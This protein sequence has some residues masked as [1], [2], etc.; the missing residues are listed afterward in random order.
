MRY[1]FYLLLP[2]F[3]SQTFYSQIVDYRPYQSPVKNQEGR[4]TCTAFSI[5]ALL[6]T[7]PAFPSDISEQHIYGSA[8]LYN[9]NKMPTY[10][11]GALLSFYINELSRRGFWPESFYPY[12]PNSE[13]WNKNFDDMSKLRA[14]L[15]GMKIFDLL[16]FK[17]SPFFVNTSGFRHFNKQE[18]RNIEFIKKTLDS[19]TKA[20][21][22]CYM[23][24]STHL[25]NHEGKRSNKLKPED[26]FVIRKDSKFYTF[27]EIKNSF[28][29]L[30][31]LFHNP[32]FSIIPKK[33]NL[34][35]N[36]GHAV[37]IVGYDE[38][39]FIIKNSWGENWGDKGYGWISFD[40]HTL[41]VKEM[42]FLNNFILNYKKGPFTTA[43]F[44]PSKLHLKSLPYFDK[45]KNGISL[46]WIYESE[47]ILPDLT[48]IKIV[49]YNA[50]DVKIGEWTR[51]FCFKTNIESNGCDLKIAIN[52]LPAGIV[53][54]KIV[55]TFYG[56]GG[57]EF[58]NT[59]SNIS[60]KNQT[61][62]PIKNKYNLLDLR[63]K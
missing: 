46:S 62:S 59:Y 61:Y 2:F 34:Q 26:L 50:Q 49:A 16:S 60:A 25:S 44:D 7:H 63:I 18:S 8:K 1:F 4:G 51:F 13:V 24:N 15:A 32:Q 48:E 33:L 20:I 35:L 40:Y 11:E 6:E 22:V 58:S 30:D 38:D 47:N 29:S 3:L 31:I 43:T 12:N 17:S 57:M 55:A 14:D 27:Q 23:I 36:G 28:G 10:Q 53:F 19:G 41:F 5:C 52:N 37:T 56:K 54:D 39:G 45:I 21:S 42:L 9:Q